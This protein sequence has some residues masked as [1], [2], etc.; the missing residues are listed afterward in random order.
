MV[1][2]IQSASPV[3]GAAWANKE[4]SPQSCAPDTTALAATALLQD[5]PPEILSAYGST[6][7]PAAIRR[8]G[9]AW[10]QPVSPSALHGSPEYG[11]G[12]PA[13]HRVQGSTR[14]RTSTALF[15]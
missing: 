14:R 11:C 10:V 6:A 9:A 3:P 1:P 15:P 13:A 7:R 8:R 12:R 2:S 5:G 4:S